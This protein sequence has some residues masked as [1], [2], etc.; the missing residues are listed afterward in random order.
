MFKFDKMK[1]W[2]NDGEEALRMEV[3]DFLQ[4]QGCRV[5]SNIKNNKAV[6]YDRGIQVN[7]NG[8]ISAATNR[9]DPYWYNILEDYKEINI[10]WMRVKKPEP[11]ELNGQRYIKAE[12]EE[13][14]RLLKPV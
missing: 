2:F 7:E 3:C 12:V 6:G 11:I 1:F 10:D 9:K 13:A 14:L 8:V 4:S 5:G